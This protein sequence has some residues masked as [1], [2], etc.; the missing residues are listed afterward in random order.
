ME[1]KINL[2]YRESLIE[3]YCNPCFDLD[4]DS[5]IIKKEL[6]EIF[7]QKPF[8]PNCGSRDFDDNNKIVWCTI[9]GETLKEM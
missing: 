8:C 5:C 4:C 1:V 6:D 9:C 7:N 2:T 3:D